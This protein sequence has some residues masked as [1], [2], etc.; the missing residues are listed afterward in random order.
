MSKSRSARPDAN[1]SGLQAREQ[2]SQS[3]FRWCNSESVPEHATGM[4]RWSL[5]P[6]DPPRTCCA[7]KVPIDVLLALRLSPSR[8]PHSPIFF[9]FFMQIL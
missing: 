8:R 2:V 7:F 9:S 1:T 4:Y 3:Q 6:S 5:K